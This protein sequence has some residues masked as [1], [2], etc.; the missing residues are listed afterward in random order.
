MLEVR[1]IAARRGGHSVFRN[2]SFTLKAGAALMVRGPNGSGKSTLLRVVAGLI[3]PEAGVIEWAHGANHQ[4]SVHYISHHSATKP[5]LATREMMSTWCALLGC[6]TQ[7]IENAAAAFGLADLLDHPVRR[8]SAGQKQRLA[9]TRLLLR[10][11]PLWLLDEPTTALDDDGRLGL[12]AVI[13]QHRA[14]AGAVIAVTHHASDTVWGAETLRL[15][16]A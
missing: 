1:Q 16:A 13:A 9:L 14:T 10:P 8:L 4:T 2:L 6:G 15:G 5:E 12:A 11:A 7:S 3:A